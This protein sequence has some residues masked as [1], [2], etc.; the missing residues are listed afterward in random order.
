MLHD[1]AEI[2][3]EPRRAGEL[4]AGLL[5]HRRELR[6][7]LRQ[8][9]H[10]RAD[11]GDGE[12]RRIDQ[13]RLDAGGQPRFA[14]EQIGK[15]RQGRGELT[16]GLAGACEAD[17]EA[18]ENLRVFG[19]ARRQRFSAAHPV[20]QI[21]DDPPRALVVIGLAEEEQR[22][23]DILA[24]PQHDRE[25]A[26][27]MGERRFRQAAP[28]AEI[29]VEKLEKAAVLPDFRRLQQ[30]LPLRIEM[31]GDRSSARGFDD[32]ANRLS[33]GVDGAV[34]ELRHEAQ[35]SRR[36]LRSSSLSDVVPAATCRRPFSNIGCMPDRHA[37]L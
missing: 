33:R 29:G 27:E 35:A 30:K 14:L 11:R 22:A 4:G 12:Q 8:E 32:A 3:Q 15:S 37:A 19:E 1:G 2:Q 18:R 36:T 20:P 17:V 16:A 24:G 10:D 9:Q 5:E 34:A 7:H 25:L 23:I 6:Q 21:L 13:R 28:D 26:G 31:V